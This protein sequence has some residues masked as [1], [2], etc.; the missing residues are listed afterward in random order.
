MKGDFAVGS[1]SQPVARLL[2]L[3][4]DCLIAIE[5]AVDDDACLLVL[6]DDRLVAGREIDD[7]ETRMAESDAPV[8][9]NPMALPVRAAVLETA[10]CP[11]QHDV[12]DRPAMRE[13]SYNAAH[14]Q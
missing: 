2:E 8:G 1:G 4:L 14:G 13:K 10:G 6:A 9:R 5:L 11:S 3:A 12:E 7:A